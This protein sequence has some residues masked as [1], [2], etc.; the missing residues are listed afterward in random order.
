MKTGP[1]WGR[2]FMNQEEALKLAFSSGTAV[3]R[4]NLYLNKEQKKKIEQQAKSKMES[5]L[6]TYYVGTKQAGIEGFAFFN[7]HIVRTMPETMMVVI[8]PDGSL[9]LVE[10]LAFYEPEDYL[11]P[12]RWLGLFRKKRLKDDLWVKRGIRNITGATLTTQAVTEAVRRT[13]A[14]FQVAI[15]PMLR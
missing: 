2:V 8:N 13:L 6:V 15:E 5:S 14:T 7:S 9:R 4:K 3:E 10:I 12:K 1:A 11:P